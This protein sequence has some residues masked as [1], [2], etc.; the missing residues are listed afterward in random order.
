MENYVHIATFTYPS[1]LTIAKSR[2]EANNINCYVRDELTIQV[3]NFLSN[4][5]GGIRLEVH[6]RHYE[7]AKNILIDSG[8]EEFIYDEKLLNTENSRKKNINKI[9]KISVQSVLV[10]CLL[11]IILIIYFLLTIG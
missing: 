8:F 3:H 9:L 6:K 1:E 4:A 7:K 11:W 10:I 2:L 5:I